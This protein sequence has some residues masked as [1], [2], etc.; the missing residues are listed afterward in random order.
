MIWRSS[1][2]I[3]RLTVLTSFKN[4]FGLICAIIWAGEEGRACANLQLK[5]SLEFKKD[6]QDKE[7]VTIKH[8]EQS[9][10]Y[11]GGSQQK[12]QGYT[13]VRMY[14]I[15]GSPMD[16]ILSSLKIKF[17]KLHPECGA[18]FQTPLINSGK[19]GTCW[20]KNEPL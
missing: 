2:P 1:S 4:L 7:Y 15:P 20:Y 5:N 12:D 17:S 3:S 11:Q 10:N 16:S 18:L 9:K 6:D 14:G 19:S 13:E 8:T